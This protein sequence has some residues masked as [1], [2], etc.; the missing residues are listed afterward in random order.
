MRRF[1]FLGCFLGLLG[2][3]G[4]KGSGSQSTGNPSPILSFIAVTPADPSNFM[5]NTQQFTAIGT[6]SDNSTQDLTLSAIWTSSNTTVAIVNMAGTAT[7]AQVGT[8]I[9]TAASGDISGNTTLSVAFAPVNTGSFTTHVPSAAAPGEGIA[10]RVFFPSTDALRYFEGAPVTVFSDGGH[11]PGDLP[12]E[13]INNEA[14]ANGY[15]LV[16]YVLPG[17]VSGTVAS[18]GVYDYRG[19]S[20]K[21]ALADVIRYALGK[22]QDTGGQL[23]ADRLPF[24]LSANV[25]VVGSS[26]GGNLAITTFAD[27]GA[28]FPEL[29]WFVGWEIPIGDQTIVVELSKTDGALNPFYLPGTCT[30]TECPWPGLAEAL[31][32]DPTVPFQLEDPATGIGLQLE[33]VLY[34]DGNSNGRFDTGEFSF[35]PLGGPGQIIGGQHRPKGYI[36]A[37]LAAAVQSQNTRLFPAGAPQW[38]TT[39]VEVE[40]YWAERDGSLAIAQAHAA[41]PTLL[42]TDIATRVDHVQMQPDHPHI[43]SFMQGWMN[44]GH[45][46]VR[47]NPDSVYMAMVT[48]RESSYFPDNS[49]NVNSPYPGI[50]QTLEPETVN[51]IPVSTSEAT[52]AAILELCDRSRS[53]NRSVDLKSVL[54]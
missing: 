23:L 22:I 28:E 54:Y 41:L 9:I 19:P 10:V 47:L 20:C 8:T 5:G 7:S 35:S 1:V 29:S 4:C 25:G 53:N 31:S 34:I 2:L 26:H 49:A 12:P 15:I 24:A 30:D 32:F 44:A 40:S 39:M 42:V 21:R 36:S 3:T 45:S 16:Y 33:G 27:H 38:L 50:E 14:T 37:E 11:G 43:R 17:G 52:G 6:Y 18:D 13:G 51:S 48:G 46:F